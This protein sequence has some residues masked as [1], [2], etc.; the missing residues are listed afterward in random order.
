MSSDDSEPEEEEEDS[1][2]WSSD[3]TTDEEKGREEAEGDTRAIRCLSKAPA[4]LHITSKEWKYEHEERVRIQRE[5]LEK[6][7]EEEIR[8]RKFDRKTMEWWRNECDDEEEGF[9]VQGAVSYTHL[10]AHET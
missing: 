8:W 9:E 6:P 10:R 3:T 1:L 5:A 2:S 4:H 7:I